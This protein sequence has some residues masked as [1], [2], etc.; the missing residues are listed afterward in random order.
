MLVFLLG[1]MLFNFLETEVF[2]SRKP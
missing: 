2:A 1:V